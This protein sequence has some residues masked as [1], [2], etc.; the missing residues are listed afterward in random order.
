MNKG[1]TDVL[2]RTGAKGAGCRA[3]APHRRAAGTQL[4]QQIGNLR[5]KLYQR[6]GG[7]AVGKV[8][9]LPQI[10]QHFDQMG[11]AATEEA[12]D[13]D[14]LLLRLSEA[15]KVGIENALQAL[16]V[17]PIAD[18]G[19]QLEAERLDLAFVVADLGNLRYAIVE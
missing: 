3:Q 4:L 5:R 9:V 13:P 6:P 14:C 19:L 11:L 10:T 12:A 7:G 1:K 18:K 16:G 8:I 15:S 2:H 17:F